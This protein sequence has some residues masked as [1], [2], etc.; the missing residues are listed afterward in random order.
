MKKIKIMMSMLLALGLFCACSSDAE[1]EG[2]DSSNPNFKDIES[3]NDSID[4]SVCSFFE[5]ELQKGYLTGTHVNDHFV[6]RDGF[7][8]EEENICYRI[9]SMEELA[10]LYHGSDVLPEIDFEKYTLLLGCKVYHDANTDVDNTKLVLVETPID[11]ELNLC[12]RHLEGE[13]GS[14]CITLEILYFAFYP[15]LKNKNITVNLIYD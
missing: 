7:F 13:W 1:F 12:T 5:K 10:S 15:K 9:N 14:V 6:I 4:E 2:I 3:T 11:Y 8:F